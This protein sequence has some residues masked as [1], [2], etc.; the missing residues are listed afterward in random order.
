MAHFKSPLKPEGKKVC[1]L[2]YE[3]LEKVLCKLIQV[4]FE[5]SRP[6]EFFVQLSPE[7]CGNLASSMPHGIAPL[8]ANNAEATKCQH[9]QWLS[10]FHVDWVDACVFMQRQCHIW[11]KTVLR[12]SFTAVGLIFWPWA[13]LQLEFSL[14][15]P[16]YGSWSI[17]RST[18]YSTI[19]S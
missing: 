19:C 18:H 7:R 13:N 10:L 14:Y 5:K 3:R 11:W 12:S 17:D 15:T 16:F 9:D 6:Q 8:S 4:S 2:D 1:S